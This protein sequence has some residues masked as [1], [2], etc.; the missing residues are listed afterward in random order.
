MQPKPANAVKLTRG[1]P[2]NIK[3]QVL[4]IYK[5]SFNSAE[6]KKLSINIAQLLGIAAS[7]FTHEMAHVM[8]AYQPLRDFCRNAP[9]KSGCTNRPQTHRDVLMRD[10]ACVYARYARTCPIAELKKINYSRE[11]RSANKLANGIISKQPPVEAAMRAVLHAA[12]EK[13]FGSLRRPAKN[14]RRILEADLSP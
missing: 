1:R 6:V 2:K 9:M 12:G 5:R 11:Q 10:V 14:A 3:S 13:Y 7:T 4:H 8:L